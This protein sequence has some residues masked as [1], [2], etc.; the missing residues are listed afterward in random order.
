MSKLV[1]EI[2]KTFDPLSIEQK[3]GRLRRAIIQWNREQQNISH[4]LIDEKRKALDE[5]M[6]S[7]LNND[8]L[9]QS[10]NS[11]LKKAYQSEEVNIP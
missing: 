8:L 1:A 9:I 10:L 4:K 3:I 11:D 7:P 2:W 6:T 5:T